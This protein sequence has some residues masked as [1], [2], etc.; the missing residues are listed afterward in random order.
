MASQSDN[1]GFI[2][3]KPPLSGLFNGVECELLALSQNQLKVHFLEESTVKDG[4][5]ELPSLQAFPE[6]IK[7]K[8]KTETKEYKLFDIE[9]KD[10]IRHIQDLLHI[11][12]KNQ[13]ITICQTQDVEASKVT[14][15]FE[16]LNFIPSAIPELS[17]KDISTRTTFLE[18]SFDAPIMIVGMTGG[19]DKGAMINR[20]L[21]AVASHHKIPMGLGSQRIALENP[22]HADIFK[23][24]DKFPD[25]FLIANIGIAQLVKGREVEDCLRAIDMVGAD[26]IAIH[27]NVLQELIQEEG[28]RHF[29]ETHR[30]IQ[31]IR[32]FL[33]VPIIVKEVGSGMDVNTAKKLNKIGV[34]AIDIGGAGGTSWSYIEGLRSS[35]E[36]TLKLGETFRNWGIPTANALKA[37]K[38]QNINSDLIATGGI[39][40]GLTVAKSVALGAQMAGVGL[41][42]FRAALTS[43]KATFMIL[44]TLLKGLKITML[45]TGSQSLDELK[46]KLIYGAPYEGAFENFNNL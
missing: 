36:G 41:P 40:D 15:G 2:S 9:E 42:L 30:K 7:V 26:A 11:I 18:R 4:V 3:I 39:R 35:H 32:E 34:Q 10:S 31:K 16:K 27:I 33:P 12:R 17:W 20:R 25:L 8:L 23:L 1:S 5:I 28:N 14:N 38:N 6:K 37:I 45:A 43:Q 29:E 21:A 44:E 13:H 22:A 46:G 24:K 19:V